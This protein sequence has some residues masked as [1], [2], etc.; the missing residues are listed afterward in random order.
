MQKSVVI[1]LKCQLNQ[2]QADELFYNCSIEHKV[3]VRIDNA[4]RINLKNF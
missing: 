4:H 1:H 3:M 2:A